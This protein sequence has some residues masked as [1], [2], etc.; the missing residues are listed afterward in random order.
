MQ[1]ASVAYQPRPAKQTKWFPVTMR[2]VSL[3]GGCCGA[4]GAYREEVSFRANGV[5]NKCRQ[6]CFRPQLS[7]SELGIATI[8]LLGTM[9]RLCHRLLLAVAGLIKR[10]R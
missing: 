5:V 9:R 10:N 8:L 6:R 1:H 3:P 4:V 2:L 7:A